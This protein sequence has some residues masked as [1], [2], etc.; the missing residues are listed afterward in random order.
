[1]SDAVLDAL[2]SDH[3]KRRYLVGTRW[4]GDRVLDALIGRLLDENDNP[5]H[6]YSRDELV[7]MLDR[8]LAARIG[9]V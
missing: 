3:P 4:E 8:H 7:A 1:V 6:G 9:G 5:A 2:F